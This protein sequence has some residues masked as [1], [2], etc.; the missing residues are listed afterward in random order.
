MVDQQRPRTPADKEKSRQQSRPVSGRQAAKSTTT[1]QPGRDPKGGPV[2]A[3]SGKAKGTPAPAS[4]GQRPPRAGTARPAAGPPRRSPASL[5][6]WGTIGLVIIVVAVLVIVKLTSSNTPAGTKSN[7]TAASAAVVQGATHI[8]ASV[9]NDVGITSPVAT[10]TN[11]TV[12]HGQ[13][14]I[15]SG[16]KPLVLYYGAEYCPY[17]AAERWALVAALS[18]FG[19]F[20]NLGQTTSSATD[21]FPSTPTFTFQKATFSS[22]YLAFQSIESTTNQPNGSGGYVLLQRPTAT[23]ANIINAYNS[24]KYF[25]TQTAGQAPIPFIDFANVVL[26]SGASYSPAILN[27]LTRDEVAAGLNDPKNPVSAVI[28]AT[29]NY[30][31]ASICAATKGQPASVC[32]SK[33]VTAAAKAMNLHF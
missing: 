10:I 12:I 33:G 22:P 27:G 14:P 26:V 5:V 31:S 17:C 11:P 19:T 32:T 3:G 16:G 1:G 28:V 23:Q 6:T 24:P 2:T 15:T 30:F 21:V 29:A 25:P 9:Y 13:P 4:K 20:T 18:R 8:P 7:F